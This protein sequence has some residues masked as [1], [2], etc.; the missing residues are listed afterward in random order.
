MWLTGAR[1]SVVSISV[2]GFER[3]A[4]LRAPVASP[5]RLYAHSLARHTGAPTTDLSQ[6]VQCRTSPTLSAVKCRH[7]AQQLSTV[8]VLRTPTWVCTALPR[9]PPSIDRSVT[10]SPCSKSP[11]TAHVSDR[12]PADHRASDVSGKCRPLVSASRSLAT[13]RGHPPNTC[14]NASMRRHF[15]AFS[16]AHRRGHRMLH[17]GRGHSLNVLWRP[18]MGTQCQFQKQRER[19]AQLPTA[20]S[21]LN[22]SDRI[23]VALIGKMITP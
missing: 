14:R 17:F 21:P 15:T 13:L 6:V 12:R 9:S 3:L 20:A 22:C 5:F 8:L 10:F 19:F 18:A 1:R 2:D 7:V 23:S 11:T 4:T 16:T